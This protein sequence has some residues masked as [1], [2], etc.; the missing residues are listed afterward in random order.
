M[1]TKNC[2]SRFRDA[3]TFSALLLV[4]PA[5]CPAQEADRLQ[6]SPPA[7][8][9]ARIIGVEPLLA[10]LSSLTAAKNLAA[11]G[12]SQIVELFWQLTGRA[13]GRQVQARVAL[14]Q[15]IGGLATNNWVTLLEARR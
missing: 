6:L 9:A 11:T 12:I 5:A 1:R 10:R 4:L 7:L 14:A 15:S 8:E 3:L 13:D 2:L